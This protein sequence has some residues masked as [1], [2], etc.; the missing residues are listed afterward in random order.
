MK[1]LLKNRN[2]AI[3]ITVIVIVLSILGGSHRSLLA[4]AYSAERHFD[5]IQRDLDTRIGLASNLQVVAERYLYI[6]EDAL[7]ELDTAIT[8]LRDAQTANEKAI[9][10]QQLT[11][12]TERMDI[13]LQ[14][15]NLSVPDERYRIQ[16]RTDLA[17]YNQIIGHS[18]YNEKVDQYNAE[19][20]GKFPA[21]ILAQLTGVPKLESFR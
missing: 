4:A 21:N 16:I 15:E 12:A 1:Q 6:G 10:N 3:V 19:V 18:K 2:V 13:V 20:L 8:N 17:S 9:A 11:A 14:N 7:V 5:D